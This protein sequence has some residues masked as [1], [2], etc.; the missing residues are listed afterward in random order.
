MNTVDFYLRLSLEDG[1]QQD[2]SN[3]ITSQREILKDYI[4]SKEEF[5]GGQ[6]REHID[7]G[8]TGTNF[9]RPA[10]QKMIA[11]VKKNE[12]KTILVKDLS[13][14][15]RDYI[16]SG[17]YIEQIFPFMQVRF[18]SVNDNYDS[19]NNENGISSLEI[20]FKN[21]VYDYYSKDISQKIRSSGKIRQE[22]GY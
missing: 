2:E 20:P 8:Y 19:K 21:L 14:F 22:K 4:H 18:I 12:V 6:I 10:F 15:A 5:T 7:D 3:S 17:A 9:N 11:M 13:R 16:E 1:D